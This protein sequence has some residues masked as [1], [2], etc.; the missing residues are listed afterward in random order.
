[1][2]KNK[3]KIGFWMSLSLVSGNMIGSGIFLLPAALAV[4]GGISILGWLFSTFGA[5]LLAIVFA[6]L[7]RIVSGIGGPYIYAREGFGR[8][9]GFMVAWGYWIS[10]WTGNAAIS[11]AAV[12]YLG[13]FWSPLGKDPLLAGLTAMGSIWFF[14]WINSMN[15]RRVG[16]VQL[17][18]TI[19]KVL[20]LF[21]IVA[22]GFFSFNV[23]N[24]RPFNLSK[25][26]NFTAITTTAALTFW[27]LTGLES[28]TIPADK[29]RNPEKTIYRA[30]LFGT[31]IVALLYIL[32]TVAVMGIIVPSDLRNSTAPFADAAQEIW[33]PWAGLLIAAG[34]AISCFGALNGWILL[35][36][37][38][39]MAAALDGVFPG[40]FR[41]RSKKGIPLPG[42]VI[43]SLL[44]SILIYMNFS[45]GLVAM[46]TFIIMLSVLTNLLPYFI[47]ALFEIKLYFQSQKKNGL[48][49]HGRLSI[50]ILAFLFTVWAI[51]GLG[52]KVI[53][54]GVVLLSLGIPVY[55][56]VT[57]RRR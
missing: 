37:Q 1:M 55:F 31:L 40:I 15:I 4:F 46:F 20:P 47:T 43:S 30:T 21:A 27:A 14:T 23:E 6:R 52:L 12:G 35:Q 36:G 51:Y 29:V 22:F 56:F 26:S 7:S 19:L 42:L 28:A 11:V 5:I 2:K 18:T 16:Y 25:V 3:Q 8:F 13:F 53:S 38:I 49:Y 32:S 34:G 10:I 44:A 24:F 50:S 33:A 48:I 9:T 39:P 54:W 41:R 57:K 17:I 45:H